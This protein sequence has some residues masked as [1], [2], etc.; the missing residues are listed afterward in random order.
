VSRQDCA[1]KYFTLPT[2]ILANHLEMIQITQLTHVD[3]SVT[4]LVSHKLSL[5]CL[6]AGIETSSTGKRDFHL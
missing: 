2:L 5:V 4:H 1:V 6:G 3:K